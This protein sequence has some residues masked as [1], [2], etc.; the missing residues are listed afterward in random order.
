MHVVAE[1]LCGYHC[2]VIVVS[3]SPATIS[4]RDVGR[5][6]HRPGGCGKDIGKACGWEHPRAPS[7]KWF[8]TEKATAAETVLDFLRNAGVGCI[9]TRKTGQARPRMYLPW[10]FPFSLALFP[11]SPFSLLLP[12][13]YWRRQGSPTRVEDIGLGQSMDTGK[14]LLPFLG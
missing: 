2:G 8:W 12:G 6:H 14:S 4:S 1:G 3:N 13:D 7:A 9:V 10:F 11:L 5:G